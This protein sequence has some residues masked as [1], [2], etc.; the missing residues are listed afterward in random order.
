MMMMVV[1]MMMSM[2]PMRYD[3]YG[4]ASVPIRT[5]QGLRVDIGAAAAQNDSQHDE[6][7]NQDVRTHFS[8]VW[9]FQWKRSRA[10]A[11][12]RVAIAVF[13][14][15]ATHKRGDRNAREI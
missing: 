14:N 1:M 5:R 12:V 6:D 15:L 10:I 13:C 8:T 3:I 9:L 2:R 11:S 4:R 7:R